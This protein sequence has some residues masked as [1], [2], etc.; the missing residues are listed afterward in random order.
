MQYLDL[1]LWDIKKIEAIQF[2]EKVDPNI[3]T[4]QEI[5]RQVLKKRFVERKINLE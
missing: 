5:I 4:S 3:N 1:Y 2:V